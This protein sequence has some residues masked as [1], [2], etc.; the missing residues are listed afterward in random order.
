MCVY[1]G[2]FVVYPATQIR[3]LMAA[4]IG[5]PKLNLSSTDFTSFVEY[6]GMLRRGDKEGAAYLADKRSKI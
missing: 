4:M 2:I 6:Y 3:S 5:R 1:I